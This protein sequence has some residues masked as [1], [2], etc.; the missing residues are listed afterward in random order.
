MI[1]KPT[2]RKFGLLGS[3]YLSQFMPFWF[4]S[5]ALPVLLRQQGMSLEAIGLLPLVAVAVTFKFLWSPLIDRYSYTRWGHYRFWIIFFQL[6]VV[7]ITVVCS[8]LDLETQLPLILLG[9]ALIGTGCASQDIA[10]DALAVRLLEPQER[11]IGNAV[12]GIGGAI[13]RMIGGGWHA[14]FAEPLGLENQSVEFSG[15]DGCCPHSSLGLS[16]T[17]S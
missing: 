6:W 10:T 3:L 15:C 2:L 5:Q 4:L 13:G 7:A 16:R 11:G 17:A 8:L 1:S 12:Q 14:D 9:L